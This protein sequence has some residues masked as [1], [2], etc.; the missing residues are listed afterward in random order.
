MKKPNAKA[1]D[2]LSRTEPPKAKDRNAR[3]QGQGP[4]TQ[5][6]VFYKE[7]KG[8]QKSF[9]GDLQF[10]GVS[11]IFDLKRPNPQIT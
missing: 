11:R 10:I 3:G 8:L 4:R 7:K 1:K 5:A 6:Q 9:S 2:S